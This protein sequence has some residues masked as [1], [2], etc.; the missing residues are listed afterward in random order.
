MRLKAKEQGVETNPICDAHHRRLGRNSR[1]RDNILQTRHHQ[2]VPSNASGEELRGLTTL[3]THKG[4]YRYKRLHMDIASASEVFTEKVR[5]IL[6]DLP[7]QVN[8]TDDILVFGKTPEE[9]HRNL[10]TLL[11][12]LEETGFIINLE[13]SEFYKEELTFFGL[14]FTPKGISPTEDRVKLFKDA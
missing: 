3:T 1:R 5:E 13:K 11:Q 12:R 4:L 9:H 10:I 6:A 14:R 8:M 2:S 7:G